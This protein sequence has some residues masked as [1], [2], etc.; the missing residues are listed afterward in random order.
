MNGYVLAQNCLT[1]V[2]LLA[3][4][5]EI[6]FIVRWFKLFMTKSKDIRAKRISAIGI[7]VSLF[8]TGTALF[9]NYYVA[10]NQYTKEF[11]MDNILVSP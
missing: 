3:F 4:L 11:G 7:A 10:V 5:T 9:A 8:I 6:V 1:I 2:A